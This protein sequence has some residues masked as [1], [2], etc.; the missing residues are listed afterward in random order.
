MNEATDLK[1]RELKLTAI[2]YARMGA[3][4]HLRATGRLP[5]RIGGLWNVIPMRLVIEERGTD[6][7]LTPDERLVYEAIIREGRLPGG[8]V[9]LTNDS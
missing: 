8:A 5:D 9:H 6:P 7:I 1:E 4:A 3:A 2:V